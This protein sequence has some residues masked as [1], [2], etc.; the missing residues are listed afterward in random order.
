MEERPISCLGFHRILIV[1]MIAWP[2]IKIHYD[3]ES[4]VRSVRLV[5]VKYMN[6]SISNMYV[7]FWEICKESPW[8]LAC[9]NG[10]A[11]R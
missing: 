1:C 7:S 4:M 11:L 10:W 2:L 5:L 8:T 6:H 3:K 9:P